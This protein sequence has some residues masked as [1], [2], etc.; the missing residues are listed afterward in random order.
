MPMKKTDSMNSHETGRACIKQ[1]KDLLRGYE[2]ENNIGIIQRPGNSTKITAQ[3]VQPVQP[4]THHQEHDEPYTGLVN[5]NLAS[6]TAPSLIYQSHRTIRSNPTKHPDRGS[7][8][9]VFRNI[10]TGDICDKF[11]N[12]HLTS[13]RGKNKGKLLPTGR[14]GA[15]FPSNGS[16][17][18]EFWIQ[19]VGEPPPRWSRV[20]HKLKKAFKGIIFTGDIEPALKSDGSTYYRVKNLRK[21]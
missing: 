11:F 8:V 9:L 7:V 4:V 10:E 3:P 2:P 14:N 12:A 13:Q 19:T 15:F 20:H 6:N 18:R 21:L 17:F 1:I 5:E 16:D